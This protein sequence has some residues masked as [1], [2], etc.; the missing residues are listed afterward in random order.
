M[1][2]RLNL[3]HLDNAVNIELI[4]SLDGKDY[5]SNE[6]AVPF[7]AFR[8][9]HGFHTGRKYLQ[10][11]FGALLNPIQGI[12]HIDNF[13]PIMISG[14]PNVIAAIQLICDEEAPLFK[15]ETTEEITLRKQLEEFSSKLQGQQAIPTSISARFSIFRTKKIEKRTTPDSVR[16]S[17]TP[18]E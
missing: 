11:M 17:M 13:P 12:I 6:N 18:K 10:T 14:A 3:A 7:L 4:S 9:Q 2:I 16:N 15:F 8:I 5:A 1:I